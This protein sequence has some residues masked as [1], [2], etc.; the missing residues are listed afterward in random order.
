LCGGH[1]E[2]F[3]VGGVA[4]CYVADGERA[5]IYYEERKD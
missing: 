3:D 1:D 4:K 5:R 2:T